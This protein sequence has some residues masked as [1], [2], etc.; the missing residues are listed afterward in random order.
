[1]RCAGST[2]VL[3]DWLIVA[4]AGVCES[5]TLQCQKFGEYHKD[6]PSSFRLND[7]FSMFPQFMFHLR[8]SQFMQVFNNSPDETAY[9]R[10]VAS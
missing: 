1:M 4:C 5:A 7:T 8:R 9:Y 2:E 6:D 3:Y 10:C